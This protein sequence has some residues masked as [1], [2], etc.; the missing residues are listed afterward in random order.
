MMKMGSDKLQRI[1]GGTGCDIVDYDVQGDVEFTA[2]RGRIYAIVVREDSTQIASVVEDQ[3]GTSVR[4]N[5]TSDRSW[6]G[7]ETGG[8]SGGDSTEG[9]PSLLQFDLIIP[10]Y[11]LTAIHVA[12]GSVLV[13][14]EEYG[15]HHYRR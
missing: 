2:R 12:A 13:Y 5:S 10:D 3:N 4:V 1:S 8:S 14:Y 15:W 6:L 9:Y 7:T 11:P